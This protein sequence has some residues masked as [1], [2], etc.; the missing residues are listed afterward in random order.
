MVMGAVGF[1]LLVPNLPALA[2]VEEPHL[3]RIHGDAYAR[4]MSRVRPVHPGRRAR[5]RR[6]R[7]ASPMNGVVGIR[8]L[9]DTD[10]PDRRAWRE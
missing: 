5:S 3:Q 1:A 2:F 6:Q 4:Y 10:V 9:A 7:R 8:K